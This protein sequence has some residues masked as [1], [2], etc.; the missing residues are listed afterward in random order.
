MTPL[1]DLDLDPGVGMTETPP[2][3]L[4]HPP[5]L[6][7]FFS[8]IP[9]AWAWPAHGSAAPGLLYGPFRHFVSQTRSTSG[10][11]RKRAAGERR[12]CGAFNT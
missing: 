2:E 11:L 8:R 10:T 12:E 4:R 9:R 1:A 5:E 3:L 6:P 7:E